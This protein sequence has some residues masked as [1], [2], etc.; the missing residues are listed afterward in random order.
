MSSWS[1]ALDLDHIR[2]LPIFHLMC[3]LTWKIY[4]AMKRESTCLGFIGF[5]HLPVSLYITS[6]INMT[7][8]LTHK[9]RENISSLNF[10]GTCMAKEKKNSAQNFYSD[11]DRYSGQVRD[12]LYWQVKHLI[13]EDPNYCYLVNMSSFFLSVGPPQ[14]EHQPFLVFVQ[15]WYDGICE[16]FPSFVFVGVG[17][18]SP[19]C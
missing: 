1:S 7:L 16:L 15:P 6:R 12:I 19:H 10:T 18:S 14:H 2:K 3:W 9:Y 4:R 17:L 8:N 13:K 5:V 11:D